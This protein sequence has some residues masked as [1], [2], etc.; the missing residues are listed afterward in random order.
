MSQALIHFLLIYNRDTDE[1]MPVQEFE[2]AGEATDA[3]G[4]AEKAAAQQGQRLDIVLVGSD[5]LRT[6]QVTHSN[7]FSGNALKRVKEA[8]M[9]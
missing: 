4:E 5:S 2:D 9:I 7:Y 1:L 8:L 6:V 3:Y